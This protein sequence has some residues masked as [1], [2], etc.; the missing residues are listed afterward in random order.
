MKVT[1]E[2]K[3]FDELFSTYKLCQEFL[4]RAK[5]KKL[6]IYEN[7]SYEHTEKN[8]KIKTKQTRKIQKGDK[9]I[10]EETKQIK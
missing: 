9:V 6:N 8:G 10:F 3:H 2:K 5:D 7:I 4:G 1:I